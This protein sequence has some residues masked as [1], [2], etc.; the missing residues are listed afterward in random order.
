MTHQL[1]A[2]DRQ[3]KRS[4]EPPRRQIVQQIND[5]SAQRQQV[6][7]QLV[8]CVR[9]AS[10]LAPGEDRF[11]SDDRS[12]SPA[13]EVFATTGPGPCS[14]YGFPGTSPRVSLLGDVP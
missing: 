12:I 11:D 10:P 9:T 7:R 1:E 13:H 8:A 3:A 14:A 5:L 6:Y 2:L 4:V